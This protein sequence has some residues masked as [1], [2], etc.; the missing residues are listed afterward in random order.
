MECVVLLSVHKQTP[1][2]CFV[3]AHVNLNSEF[4][5][6][7]R[8]KSCDSSCLSCKMQFNKNGGRRLLRNAE[9]EGL[10]KTLSICC[11]AKTMASSSGGQQTAVRICAGMA[12]Q[13]HYRRCHLAFGPTVLLRLR[14]IKSQVLLIP[15]P[16]GS[17]KN[18]R[19]LLNSETDLLT[20]ASPMC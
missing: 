16:R 8:P 9:G 7:M 10:G 20:E 3:L 12:P 5:G 18:M 2:S 14:L 11:S 19:L 13:P 1:L 15:N 17:L 6:S 4:S